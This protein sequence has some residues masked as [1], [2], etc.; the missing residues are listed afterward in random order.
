M[1]SARTMLYKS[2]G[3]YWE[4]I[5]QILAY[6]FTSLSRR[7][8][9]AMLNIKEDILLKTRYFRDVA[10]EAA[11]E[12]HNKGLQKG[13]KEGLKEGLEKGLEEGKVETALRIA[14]RMLAK[15]L[16]LDLIAETTGL[17]LSK[18]RTLSAAKSRTR[19]KKTS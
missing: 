11:E 8:I 12:G 10:K 16:S 7:Q 4:I 18:L 6:K 1:A 5:E 13:L 19:R 3:K 15:K 2:G 9:Q 17:S 14:R